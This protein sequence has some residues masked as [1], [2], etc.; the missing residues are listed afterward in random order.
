MPSRRKDKFG[1]YH[2]KHK[3]NSANFQ[4]DWTAK[5]GTIEVK[6]QVEIEQGNKVE[7][8][9]QIDLKELMDDNMKEKRR[10]LIKENHPDRGGTEEKLK[11]VLDEYGEK[12]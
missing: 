5:D 7:V 10:E 9:T 11:K 4:R 1:E 3:Y 8:E 12:S 2:G 6:S